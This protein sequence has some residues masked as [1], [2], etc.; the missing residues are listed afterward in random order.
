MTNHLTPSAV[1]IVAVHLLDSAQGVSLQTW[2]F[3]GRSSI[4]IGRGDEND[5][6]I[7]DPHVSRTHVK[8]VEQDGAWTLHSSGRHGTLLNDRLITQAEF[9][10]TTVFRLGA[11]GPLLR[12]EPRASEP[13]RSET[14]DGIASDMMAF[15]EIDKDRTKQ[16]ADQIADSEL[17]RDLMEQSRRMRGSGENT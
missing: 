13:H 10:E 7:S 6:V 11:G 5:V 4:S 1:R 3:S 12:F 14:I 2:R 17:F 9:A 8:L 15:L 16:E